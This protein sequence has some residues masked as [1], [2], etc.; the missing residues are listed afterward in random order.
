MGILSS[1]R[2]TRALGAPGTKE[3]GEGRV[4]TLSGNDAVDHSAAA[5]RCS[6]LG[7]GR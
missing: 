3:K 7:M 6:A 4:P 5:P 2:G 1:A